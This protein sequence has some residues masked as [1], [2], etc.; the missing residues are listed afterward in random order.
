[1]CIPPHWA[2]EVPLPEPFRQVGKFLQGTPLPGQPTQL[3]PVQSDAW[4]RLLHLADLTCK[5][6]QTSAQLH[7]VTVI[8]LRPHYCS[9][10]QKLRIS[11]LLIVRWLKPAT[12]KYTCMFL[13]LKRAETVWKEEPF[14]LAT[15]FFPPSA[16]RNNIG[17]CL[18]A[19]QWKFFSPVD[20]IVASSYVEELTRNTLEW[21]WVWTQDL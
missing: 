21:N 4:G 11:T 16:E 1:M 19:D 13:T 8:Q 2:N 17:P 20:W 6:H 18:L 15:F 5:Y 3:V 12:G 9:C 14:F 7:Q 10:I